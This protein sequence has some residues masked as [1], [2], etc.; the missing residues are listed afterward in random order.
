MSDITSK[1]HIWAYVLEHGKVNTK[2]S[3]W[4]GLSLMNTTFGER[5]DE[6]QKNCLAH[7]KYIG[8][9]W[10]KTEFPIQ[11]VAYTFDGTDRDSRAENY[12]RGS[13]VLTDGSKIQCCIGHH[14]VAEYNQAVAYIK[15]QHKDIA[16]IVNKA[17]FNNLEI[18]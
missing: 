8:I 5:F 13:L 7:I 18:L 2:A 9:D 14:D 15:G 11:D 17:V 1:K 3:Y 12:I 10:D 16:T 6:S 4:G